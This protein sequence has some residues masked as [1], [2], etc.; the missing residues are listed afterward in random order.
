VNRYSPSPSLP[1]R[2]GRGRLRASRL[3]LYKAY[4]DRYGTHPGPREGCIEC[5]RLLLEAGGDP[6]A[7]D[8][9]G[10]TALD[11]ARGARRTTMAAFPEGI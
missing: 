5:A 2:S 3:A 11:V 8:A 6:G 1:R 4:V 9:G 7:T 10:R